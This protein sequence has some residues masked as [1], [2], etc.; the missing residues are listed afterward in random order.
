VSPTHDRRRRDLILLIFCPLALTS[1]GCAR[2]G[3]EQLL[4]E[5]FFSL[6]RLR[7][8]TG[9]QRVSTVTFEPLRDGIVAGFTIEGVTGP[10]N[11]GNGL[12]KRV[13]VSASVRLPD[14][15]TAKRRIALVLEQRDRWIV[16]GFT[17]LGP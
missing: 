3:A 13:T 6:S 11:G 12:S 9:L 1:A 2:Y 14:G 10:E 5:E 4:L 17:V 8:R 16:T 7:D 15:A